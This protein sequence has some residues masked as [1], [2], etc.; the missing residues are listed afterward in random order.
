MSEKDYLLRFSGG[1]GF[2]TLPTEILQ[3]VER[4]RKLCREHGERNHK[5]TKLDDGDWRRVIKFL[6][7]DLNEV[8]GAPEDDPDRLREEVD[9]EWYSSLPYTEVRSLNTLPL[10]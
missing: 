10:T 2:S 1:G 4:Y 5:K 6:C 9:R 8:D 3:I 7:G